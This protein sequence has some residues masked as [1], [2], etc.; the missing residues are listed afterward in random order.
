MGLEVEAK[1]D[2]DHADPRAILDQLASLDGLSAYCLGDLAA[3]HQ[4]DTYF[5]TPDQRLARAD[6]GLR[7][8]EK[9]GRTTVTLKLRAAAGGA[10]IHSRQEIE[11]EPAAALL[12]EVGSALQQAGLLE[13]AGVEVTA[14][15][16]VVFAGWGFAPLVTITNW[17]RTRDVLGDGG[18]QLAELALDV[19][20][21]GG[22]SRS[23]RFYEVEVEAAAGVSGDLLVEIVAAL[24]AGVPGAL[25]PN[26]V[27]KYRRALSLLGL[28]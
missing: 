11:G 5:D 25:A 17:R 27:S 14:D 1:F 12:G 7:L 8:R 23:A 20:E 15:P 18:R 21:V 10:G 19:V 16:V 6:A 2:V 28:D 26:R 9:D 22:G 13:T 24:R 4:R 3:R